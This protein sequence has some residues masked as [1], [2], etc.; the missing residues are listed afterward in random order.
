MEDS[1]RL[2]LEECDSL[3][4]R[5]RFIDGLHLRR[6]LLPEEYCLRICF[7]GST[8]HLEQ[9][10]VQGVPLPFQYFHLPSPVS[11]HEAQPIDSSSVSS[12]QLNS[13]AGIAGFE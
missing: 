2:A 5:I 8:S 6:C 10:Q 12:S 4:V 9:P 13:R 7:S 11:E 3:Q 1:V